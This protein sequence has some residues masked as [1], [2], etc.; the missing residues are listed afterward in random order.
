VA[1]GSILKIGFTS[2]PPERGEERGEYPRRRRPAQP[3]TKERPAQ[4]SLI[5]TQPKETGED[6]GEDP[7][8]WG[9]ERGVLKKGLTLSKKEKK[10]LTQV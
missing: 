2:A 6:L 8:I 5:T 1:N 7:I 3:S 4:H 9:N 10:G